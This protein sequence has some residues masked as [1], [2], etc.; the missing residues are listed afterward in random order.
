MFDGGCM[1]EKS[2]E[3][4]KRKDRDKGAAVGYV[5]DMPHSRRRRRPPLPRAARLESRHK[6]KAEWGEKKKDSRV[7]QE[8]AGAGF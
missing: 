2:G 1:C 4:K 5:P 3:R 8:T 7:R 6:R